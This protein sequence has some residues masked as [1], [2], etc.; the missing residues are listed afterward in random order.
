MATVCVLPDS[1]TIAVRPNET[2]LHAL[3]RSG[4]GYRTGCTRGGCG[5]CKVDLVEGAVDY[6]ARVAETVLSPQEIAAG[7]CLSCRAIPLT[8]I[9]IALRN[10]RLRRLNPYLTTTSAPP[11][12]KGQ[13]AWE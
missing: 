2:I 7:T 4:Y 13:S 5:I 10:E 12:L 3:Y 6:A 9:I 11:E 8:D 1:V